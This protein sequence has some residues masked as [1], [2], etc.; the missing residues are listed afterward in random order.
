MGS[1]AH[2][3][4]DAKHYCDDEI[5]KIKTQ[6]VDT[7]NLAS[8]EELS[9]SLAGKANA[10]EVYTKEEVDE[11]IA[12]VDV[13]EQLADY[14][15]KEE[16]ESKV[17]EINTSLADKADADNVYDKD[18]IDSKVDEINTAIA[19]KANAS[20]V[21]SKQEVDDAIASV[22]VSDQLSDYA[23]KDETT[24]IKDQDGNVIKEFVLDSSD[25]DDT[26]EVYTRE[27]VD[28][29]IAAALSNVPKVIPISADDYEALTEKDANTLYI[30]QKVA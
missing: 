1:L 30:I 23:K 11:A 14:A 7:S 20:E 18:A 13:S 22:D 27:Q 15:T 6:Q 2:A 28:A 19:D 5:A 26:V 12:G 4:H 21:Y 16:V 9:E 3:V 10:S 29:L 24:V 17:D 25:E 8:K